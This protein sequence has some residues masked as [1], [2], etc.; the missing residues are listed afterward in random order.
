MRHQRIRT[1][2]NQDCRVRGDVRTGP[3]LL[4]GPAVGLAVGLAVGFAARFAVGTF[5]LAAACVSD[6]ASW[7]R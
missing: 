6:T 5:C 1:G 2:S 3:L 7:S 4:R